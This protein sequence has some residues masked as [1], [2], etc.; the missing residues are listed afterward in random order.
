MLG[1]MTSLVSHPLQSPLSGTARVPGDKSISHRALMFGA[2]ANGVTEITGL[3]EGEDVIHTAEALE[4]MGAQI[5]RPA[6]AGGIWHV[7]GV[8]TGGLKSPARDIYLGNSGTSTRLL[9]GL[10]GGYPVRATFTGDASLSKRPMARVSKP[11]EDMGVKITATYGGKL[12]LTVEGAETLRE[13]SYTLPVASAQVKSA[14]ILAA[15]SC[16]GESTV[17]E[18]E[19][20]I[21]NACCA[22]LA[23]ISKAARATRVRISSRYA[24]SPF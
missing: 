17:I 16:A 8:G 13:I 24:A 15:L 6:Q 1:R 5:V 19:P 22:F 21:P 11:L 14:I 4:A 10:V 12:P 9:M 20:T 23:R 3:L 7:T 18:P 2:L